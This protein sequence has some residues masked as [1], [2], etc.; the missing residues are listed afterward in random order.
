MIKLDNHRKLKQHEII[1]EG[2]LYQDAQGEIR[3][4]KF[5]IGRNPSGYILNTFWRRKH[6]KKPLNVVIRIPR[7]KDTTASDKTKNVTIVTFQY[8]HNYVPRGRIVQLIK[9][10]GQYVTGLERTGYSGEYKY[11]FKR[12]L[13]NRI[14][15]SITLVHFGPPQK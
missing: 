7:S 3:R 6:T 15:G 10:D 11:Q 14:Q 1:R 8:S 5:S 9:V 4:V 2:D 13:R 12:F